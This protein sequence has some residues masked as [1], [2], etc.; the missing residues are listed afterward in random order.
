MTC[1]QRTENT[2]LVSGAVNPPRHSLNLSS[3]INSRGIQSRKIQEN[4]R[5]VTNSYLLDS[6]RIFENSKIQ[7]MTKSSQSGFTLVELSIVLVII[8]LIVGGVVG[9]NSLVQSAKLKNTVSQFQK[10]QISYNMFKDKYDAMPGDITTATSYWGTSPYYCNAVLGSCNGNGDNKVTAWTLELRTFWIHMVDAG[11]LPRLNEDPWNSDLSKAMP[12]SKI[13]KGTFLAMNDQLSGKNVTALSIMLSE[14][15]ADGIP[16]V[17]VLTTQEASDIDRKM[18][19]GF[20]ASGKYIT[21]NG[22]DPNNH[23]V[24]LTT[25]LTGTNYN[26]ATQ[27]PACVSYYILDK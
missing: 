23:T 15:Y 16:W 3:R 2:G 7:G 6:P 9:G 12:K 18:D 20:P 19:D 5:E 24:G 4:F 8:G 13:R 26:F 22:R 25:C 27:T 10:F 1:E 11:L 21:Q 17:A 14:M